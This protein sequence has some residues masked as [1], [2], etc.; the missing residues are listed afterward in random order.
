MQFARQI[1]SY[2]T[3]AALRGHFQA[4]SSC[5]SHRE[6]PGYRSNVTLVA[7]TAKAG[8]TE[9]LS[10][11]TAAVLPC[12]GTRSTSVHVSEVTAGYLALTYHH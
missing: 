11:G 8:P 5:Y 6:S 4:R 3:A 1:T 9:S 2:S 12:L 10:E 7:A